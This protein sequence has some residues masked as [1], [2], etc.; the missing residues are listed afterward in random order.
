MREH[1][2]T[3]E[4]AMKEIERIGASAAQDKNQLVRWVANKESHAN[5]LS[6]IVT[7]YFMAQRVKPVSTDQKAAHSAYVN[8][9]T[10]LHQILVQ[11]MKAKQSTK[12]EHCA[13]L[14]ALIAQFEAIYGR[15]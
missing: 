12:R 11:T 2:V 3:I 10:I 1:V 7:S 5:E 14:R 6:E 13:Q 15:K 8:Q 9:V 4:K